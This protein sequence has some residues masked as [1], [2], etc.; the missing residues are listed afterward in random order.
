[1]I[2]KFSDK[3]LQ[4]I[5]IQYGEVTHPPVTAEYKVLK[6]VRPY[7]PEALAKKLKSKNSV[8]LAESDRIIG[9]GGSTITYNAQTK[10][11]I[12]PYTGLTPNFFCPL[13]QIRTMASNEDSSNDVRCIYPGCKNPTHPLHTFPPSMKDTALWLQQLG[14]QQD[15]KI[16]ER[17]R[18]CT[19]HFDRTKQVKPSFPSLRTA[20]MNK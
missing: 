16:M 9:G 8:D 13:F 20:I 1:M 17:D 3:K 5:H 14:L 19:N 4:Q 10:F 6:F 11:Y 7:S 12:F 18:V 15:Y 2:A